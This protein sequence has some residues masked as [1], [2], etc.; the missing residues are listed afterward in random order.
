MCWPSAV[1]WAT[2][3]ICAV[4]LP[5]GLGGAPVRGTTVVLSPG[6]G[7]W[8]GRWLPGC[9]DRHPTRPALV[10]RMTCRTE[11]WQPASQ[12]HAGKPCAQGR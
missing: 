5:V 1:S 6:G 4:P 12:K 2:R 10:E 9:F 8:R 7:A 3:R 11:Q